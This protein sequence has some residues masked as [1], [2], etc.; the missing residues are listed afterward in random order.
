MAMAL[1]FVVTHRKQTHGLTNQLMA[2][3]AMLRVADTL[4]RQGYRVGITV[5]DVGCRK[6]LDH[7]VKDYAV[8]SSR[9]ASALYDEEALLSLLGEAA[10]TI[11]AEGEKS[12]AMD[13]FAKFQPAGSEH[14]GLHD[15]EG[16]QYKLDNLQFLGEMQTL[17]MGTPSGVP[18]PLT[19]RIFTFNAF[20]FAW[21]DRV[22]AA[23]RKDLI[24]M[25]DDVAGDLGV[26][27]ALTLHLRLEKDMSH[28]APVA[29]IACTLSRLRRDSR[30]SIDMDTTVYLCGAVDEARKQMVRDTLGVQNIVTKEDSEHFARQEFADINGVI[31]LLVCMRGREFIGYNMSTFSWIIARYLAHRDS[32]TAMYCPN[33]ALFSLE[34]HFVYDDLSRP[35]IEVYDC[36]SRRDAG[37]LPA[38]GAPRRSEQASSLVAVVLIAVFSVIFV[39]LVLSAALLPHY[40]RRSNPTPPTAAIEM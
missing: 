38:M 8:Y 33:N 29:N 24:A 9:P 17:R 34:D 20:D 27:N 30:L 16:T 28:M 32:Y 5:P 31:D 25:A 21:G 15:I 2:V 14:R 35:N 19:C 22:M 10:D 4:R 23:L 12:A 3:T 11:V 18:I 40:I 13:A 7:G 36:A 6:T 37:P 1:D 39:Y 26:Q